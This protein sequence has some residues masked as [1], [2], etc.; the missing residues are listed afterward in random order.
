MWMGWDLKALARMWLQNFIDR[1][2][3][4][5]SYQC[6]LPRHKELYALWILL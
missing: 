2:D 5:K 1:W 3:D 6:A 4:N